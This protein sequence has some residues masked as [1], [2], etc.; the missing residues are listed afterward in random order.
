MVSKVYEFLSVINQILS[1]AAGDSPDDGIDITF[2]ESRLSILFPPSAAVEAEAAEVSPD[3]VA[4]DVKVVAVVEKG[5]LHQSR[6]DA[7]PEEL[8]LVVGGGDG[9]AAAAAAA[10]RIHAALQATL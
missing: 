8:L 1:E 2:H 5:G 3:I 7:A 10:A 9:G 4:E 6:A